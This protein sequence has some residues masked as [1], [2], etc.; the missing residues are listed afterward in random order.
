MEIEKEMPGQFILNMAETKLT[1]HPE[2]LI[3]NV[4]S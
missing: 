4:V 3:F 1:L 2:V